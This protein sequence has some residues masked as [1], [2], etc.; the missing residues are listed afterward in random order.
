MSPSATLAE[1]EDA[2]R[3]LEK[4]VSQGAITAA[5]F[6]RTYLFAQQYE[7]AQDAHR[8]IATCAGRRA[9]KSTAVACMLLAAALKYPGRV[10]LYLNLS[11]VQARGVLWGPLLMLNERFRLGGVPNI[12]DHALYFP[13]GASVVLMG[14]N[15]RPSIENKRGFGFSIVVIDESQSV[16]EYLKKLVDDVLTPALADVRGK[17]VMIGTPSLVPRGYWHDCFHGDPKVW[18]RYAWT[19]FENP[20]IKD[21]QQTIDEELAR[22]KVT[23]DDAGIQREWF[24]RWIRD[25][26]SAVFSFDLDRNTYREL[27][28]DLDPAGWRYVVAIDIGGGVERDNDA[29]TVFAFHRHR[30]ATYLTEERVEP[31]QDVTT[32]ALAVKAIVERLGRSR[33]VAIV[34]DTGGIGAKVAVEMRARYRLAVTAAKK[35][36]KWANIELLNAACRHGEFYALAGSQFAQECVKVEK[37]W[38]KST[39]DRIVVKGHMPDV[40]D[41]AIYGFVESR[42][43]TA[44]APPKTPEE[45]RAEL[46]EIVKRASTPPAAEEVNKKARADMEEYSRE[47]ARQQREQDRL[48]QI[49][50]GQW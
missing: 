31:K 8:F 47:L 15:D 26:S 4:R 17:L 42:A 39:P 32:L 16:P 45:Q 30:R 20:F 33:V 13:N 27:P 19:L 25:V 44:K 35:A 28:K 3:F 36:D 23:I 14:V 24:G 46:A 29:I 6:L 18:G 10:A 41:S 11:L 2:E 50:W 49:N 43:W 5:D 37:D 22:R 9:G 34:A 7:M 48:E 40:V 21:P 38:D 12:T 1:L